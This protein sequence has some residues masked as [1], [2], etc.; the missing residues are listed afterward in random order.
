[1][2]IQLA[3]DD[4]PPATLSLEEYLHSSWGPDCDFVDG[5]T[6][7]RNVGTFN[8]SSMVGA[9]LWMLADKRE[10]WDV[11]A[12]PSLRMRVS[13]ARVRIPDVC[14]ICRGGPH[15]QVL[16]RPPLAV[17]EVL[18][19]EDRFSATLEKLE[20]F[21]RFGV[22]YIWVINPERR[23][24]YRHSSGSLEM[25]RTGELAVPGTPIRVVPGELFAE[26]DRA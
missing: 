12:L 10:P 19:D 8:H 18:D 21:R 6:E 22:E 20:D 2:K 24:V 5:R 16:T 3:E 17:I 14:V 7:E 26:L 9:L 13:P 1:M 15:E 23:T 11:L 4:R 25:V